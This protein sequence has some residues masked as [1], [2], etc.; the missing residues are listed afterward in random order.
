[1]NKLIF[2]VFYF[3]VVATVAMS[4][5]TLYTVESFT[6]ADYVLSLMLLAIIGKIFGIEE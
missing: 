5:I 3:V 1:M 4:M 2:I 6:S